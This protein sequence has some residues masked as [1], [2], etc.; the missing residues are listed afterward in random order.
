LSQARINAAPS[1]RKTPPAL[2]HVGQRQRS[3]A[4]SMH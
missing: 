3:S 2:H 4:L 1:M